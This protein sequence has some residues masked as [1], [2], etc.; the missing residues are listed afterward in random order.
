MEVKK[1]Q[2]FKLRAILKKIYRPINGPAMK[3]KLKALF[4]SKKGEH[5]FRL[6][7]STIGLTMQHAIHYARDI[8]VN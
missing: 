6:D 5:S 1:K 2:L 8:L 4:F 3:V 7:P